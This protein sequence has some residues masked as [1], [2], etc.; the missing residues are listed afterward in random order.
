MPMLKRKCYVDFVLLHQYF[1]NIRL[2]SPQL[3]K[4]GYYLQLC[5]SLKTPLL[6]IMQEKHRIELRLRKIH[7]HYVV[8]NCRCF[9]KLFLLNQIVNFSHCSAIFQVHCFHLMLNILYIF[10]NDFKNTPKASEQTDLVLNYVLSG[11]LTVI[12]LDYWISCC[13]RHAATLVLCRCDWP[14]IRHGVTREQRRKLESKILTVQRVLM[15]YCVC[16]LATCTIITLEIKLLG[17]L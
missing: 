17:L 12:V 9:E 15:T 16:I 14:S 11:N 3:F 4:T 8:R 10:L 6:I 2:P 1:K 13:G 5:L 7:L